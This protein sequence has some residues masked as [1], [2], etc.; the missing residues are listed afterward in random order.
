MSKTFRNFLLVGGLAAVANW[1]SRFA[2]EKV[3]SLG[4][5]VVAAYLVGMT[6]AYVMNRLF[7]F[8]ASGRKVH[9]E[10]ARFALVNLFALGVVEIVTEGLVRWGFPLVGFTWHAEAIAHGIG[11]L[12]PAVPSYLG[13]RLFTFAKAPDGAKAPQT[14]PVTAG[15]A[16]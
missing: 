3:M 8:E 7:V 5:A 1:G 2:F 4:W 6:T 13:H 10:A 15:D 12:S 11:V 14:A 9:H 16:P